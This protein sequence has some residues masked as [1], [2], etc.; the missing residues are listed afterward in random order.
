MAL[1]TWSPLTGFVG[2][3]TA[4]DRL[5]NDGMAR[6][7]GALRRTSPRYDLYETEDGY[8][9]RFAVPGI[10]PEAVEMTVN[11]GTLSVKGSYP[12]AEEHADRTWH[13]RGLPQS[14][15]FQYTFR[16][17]TAVDADRADASFEHGILTLSLPKAEAAK[18]KRIEI[19]APAQG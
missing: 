11:Q 16:L 17:P 6:S 9:F 2:L 8:T 14:G 12:Q 10:R 18:P 7:N 4:M 5:M 13:V 1:T 3:S 19:N 15:E